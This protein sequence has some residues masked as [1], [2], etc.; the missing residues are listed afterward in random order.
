M[1][2]NATPEYV[3][4]EQEFLLAQTPEEKIEKL[5]KMI[6]LAPKHKSSENLLAN[7]KTRLKKL[8]EKQEK[9]K[10]IR[11]A[12]GDCWA[13]KFWKILSVILIN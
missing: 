10:K 11:N 9:N 2:V 4:A 8:L 5:K 12:G 1:P 13:Y 3:T 6:S 7:L